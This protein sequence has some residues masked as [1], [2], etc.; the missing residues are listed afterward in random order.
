M[1]KISFWEKAVI[2]IFCAVGYA[3][4]ARF[5]LD[6]SMTLIIKAMIGFTIFGCVMYF[7]NA[8]RYAKDADVGSVMRRHG[9]IAYET[10]GG[11]L[12]IRDR[13]AGDKDL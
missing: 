6:H 10:L 3:L 1:K 8:S 13:H 2:V 11:R 7:F 5:G 9:K 12:V 4:Y